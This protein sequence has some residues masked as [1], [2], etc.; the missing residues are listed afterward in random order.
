[1]CEI[2]REKRA[3]K[4]SKNRRLMDRLESDADIRRECGLWEGGRRAKRRTHDERNNKER[5]GTASTG[6]ERETEKQGAKIHSRSIQSSHPLLPSQWHQDWPRPPLFSAS[7]LASWY[8]GQDHLS[9]CEREKDMIIPF[10]LR[11]RDPCSCSRVIILFLSYDYLFSLSVPVFACYPTFSLTGNR[12]ES[13]HEMSIPCLFL[14]PVHE[15]RERERERA[16]LLFCLMLVLVPGDR[17]PLSP[18]ISCLSG[19]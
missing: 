13:T 11:L 15:S 5:N 10:S 4:V 18:D 1:M 12:H 16:D 2:E 3:R 6:K 17:N 14:P 9:T 8:S 7:L 19:C